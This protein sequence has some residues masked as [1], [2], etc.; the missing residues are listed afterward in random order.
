MT[1]G[2]NKEAMKEVEV[3]QQF[4]AHRGGARRTIEA[5]EKEWET[6]DLGLLRTKSYTSARG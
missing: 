5:T 2:G 3:I 1:K 6:M 4:I